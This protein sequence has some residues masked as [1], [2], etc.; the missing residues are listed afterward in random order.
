[1][2]DTLLTSRAAGVLTLTLHRP[3]KRNALSSELIAALTAAIADA[4]LDPDVRVM[5]LRGAGPDFCAGADLAEL[6]ASVDRSPADNEA[7]ARRLGELF[8]AL[9]ALPKPVVAAVHGNAVGGG[10]GLATA[11]DLILAQTGARFGYPEI[12]RGFVPAMVLTLLRRS[13]GEK[14]AFDLVTTGRLLSAEE[15]CTAGLVSRILS[16]ETFDVEVA[17]VCSALAGMSATALGLTKKLFYELDGL[18]MAEGI[19][20]GARV[21]ASARSTRE[22]R[23]LVEGFLRR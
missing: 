20:L 4:E 12:R 18:G 3:D 5:L 23:E 16:P 8:L 13:V 22:F 14:I 19:R 17:S 11:C 9:R 10:C 15:A 21:N 1:M 2:S 6:L 7:D